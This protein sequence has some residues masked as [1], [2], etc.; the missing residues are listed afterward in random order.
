MTTSISPV[1][2]PAIIALLWAAVLNLDSAAILIGNPEYRDVK[3]LKCCCTSNVVGTKM[4][5]CFPS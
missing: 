1:A 4:A 5:T 2:N 3:V